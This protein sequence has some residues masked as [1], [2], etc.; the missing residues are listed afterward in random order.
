MM[1]TP[2]VF[3]KEK[4]HD[5]RGFFTQIWS[6]FYPWEEIEAK[7]VQENLSE[8]KKNVFRGMHWQI[9]PFEQGKLVTVL[10]GAI[11]D[12]IVDLRLGS[13]DFGKGIKFSLESESQSSLWV[14]PG[15]AHGF[16]SLEEGTMVLY[17]VTKPW[18]P[19]LERS[20]SPDSL[21]GL[22]GLATSDLTLS[23]KDRNAPKFP[24]LSEEDCF[25]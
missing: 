2:K 12:F 23:L 24:E 6:D 1:R 21:E 7:P 14:P 16:L 25:E 13:V 4:F 11:V 3:K 15:F 18:N 8:S 9:P 20:F 17:Q 22:F 10:H 19:D 5:D